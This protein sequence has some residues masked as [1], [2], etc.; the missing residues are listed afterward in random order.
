MCSPDFTPLVEKY[1][2]RIIADCKG[3]IKTYLQHVVDH[4]N[5]MR[6]AEFEY[7][8]LFPFKAMKITEKTVI[9]KVPMIF[10]NEEV[11]K[12][13]KVMKLD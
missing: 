9:I 13:I 8:F 3:G 4:R 6:W 5:E 2:E 7:C 12:L 1:I 10:Q 11:D